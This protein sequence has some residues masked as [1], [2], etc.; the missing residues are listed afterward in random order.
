[1][2]GKLLDLSSNRFKRTVIT[3]SFICAACIRNAVRR[4]RIKIPACGSDA[5]HGLE[6]VF[7]ALRTP[8]RVKYGVNGESGE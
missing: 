2:A 7:K 5:L 6:V 1:M 4:K 3:G 8:R